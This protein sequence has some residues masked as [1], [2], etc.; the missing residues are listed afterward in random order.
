MAD[1]EICAADKGGGELC[2]NPAGYGTNHPGIGRCKWHYGSTP[3]HEHAANKI[4]IRQIAEEAAQRRGLPP[5]TVDPAQ[6]LS[7]E[8]NRAYG[9]VLAIEEITDLNS[10]TW[11]EWQKVWMEERKHAVTL[12]KLMIDSGIAERLTRVQEVQV[13]QLA[14]AMRQVLDGLQL[15]AEQQ[16]LARDLVPKVLKAIPTN[17]TEEPTDAFPPS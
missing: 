5:G 8:L 7:E 6:V 15:T 16:A 17:A 14:M 4:K 9:I 2:Q 11:P 1:G 12:A 3:S 10:A 13:I